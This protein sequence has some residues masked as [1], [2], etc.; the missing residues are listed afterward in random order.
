VSR[1]GAGPTLGDVVSAAALVLG[2]ITAWLYVTGWTYAYH[3]FDAFRI[4]M[5]MADLP[6]EHLFV[7][8]GLVVWK[9]LV[10]SIV[11]A[12]AV[13]AAIAGCIRYRGWLRRFAITTIVV[14]LVLT[15]F[16][17]GR[18]AAVLTAQ[19]DLQTQR[20]SDYDAYPRV[21]FALEDTASPGQELLAD[22]AD[23]DCGRLVLGTADWLFFIRPIRGAAAVRLDTFVISRN[24]LK[25]LRLKADHTSCP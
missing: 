1:E 11:I 12:L 15:I 21:R 9:N 20:A 4:P 24:H 7:Y 2:L 6:K 19:A 8:G 17:L 22:L 23:S 10:A 25:S 3:Y 14:I 5:R 16:A 13:V 18:F